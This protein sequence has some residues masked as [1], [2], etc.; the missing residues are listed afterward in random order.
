M[1]PNFSIVAPVLWSLRSKWET[2]ETQAPPFFP[3][4][5]EPLAQGLQRGGVAAD[6]DD[7]HLEMAPPF[8]RIQGGENLLV[9]EVAS[10][11]EEDEGV[12]P[13][14]VHAA[15]LISRVSPDDRRTHSACER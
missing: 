2:R 15:F 12:G 9:Y 1:A 3:D 13:R 14:K 6:P 10:S 11:A 7:G 4:G 5:L 8:H